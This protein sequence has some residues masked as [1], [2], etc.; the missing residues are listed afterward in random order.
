MTTR[1]LT[2]FFL[3]AILAGAAAPLLAQG[4]RP[5]AGPKTLKPAPWVQGGGAG[6][7]LS[8][9]ERLALE[10]Q[11][12]WQT[13]QELWRVM[14]QYPPAVGEILQRDPSLLEKADYMAAYPVLGEFLKAHPEVAR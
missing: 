11:N 3:A 8:D 12:A 7:V 6:R 2:T 9:G 13:Q 4:E 10:G 1:A 14:R 5:V